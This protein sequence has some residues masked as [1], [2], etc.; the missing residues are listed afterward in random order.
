[1]RAREHQDRLAH[2]PFQLLLVEFATLGDGVYSGDL[3]SRRLHLLVHRCGVREWRRPGHFVTLR[4]VVEHLA[5]LADVAGASAFR[6][7]DSAWLQHARCRT[8]ELALVTHPWVVE[9]VSDTPSINGRPNRS[10]SMLRS[11]VLWPLPIGGHGT[12]CASSPDLR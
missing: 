6:V 12:C 3:E 4:E 2:Q 11:T 1:M 10:S 8:E 9:R 7:Q 5:D